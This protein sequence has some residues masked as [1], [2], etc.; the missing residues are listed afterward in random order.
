MTNLPPIY[1]LENISQLVDYCIK[2][3][4]N[5]ISKKQHNSAKSEQN[6][7]DSIN[8]LE[9]DYLTSY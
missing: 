1:C 7:D 5:M 6:F 4:E 3:K 2:N 9:T 8:I